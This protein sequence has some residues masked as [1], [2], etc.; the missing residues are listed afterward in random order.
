M[1]YPPKYCPYCAMMF[2]PTR[3]NQK[4]CGKPEC[5]TQRTKRLRRRWMMDKPQYMKHY[6]RARRLILVYKKQRYGYQVV[7]RMV[8]KLVKD[9]PK[10]YKWM[11]R[12]IYKGGNFHDGRAEHNR[13]D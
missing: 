7:K 12:N 13:T 9:V 1:E 8:E 6:M 10:S 2:Q 11:Y 4:V 5:K 3:H